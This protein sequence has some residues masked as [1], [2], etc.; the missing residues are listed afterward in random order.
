MAPAIAR[1]RARISQD[2]RHGDRRDTAHDRAQRERDEAHLRAQSRDTR[3]DRG[4]GS[5][6]GERCRGL[7]RE[8]EELRAR[9]DREWNPAER[10][11]TEFRLREVREQEERCR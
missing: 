11:R 3:Y 5:D 4:Y 8:A 10:Q 1:D 2:Y 9:L 6:R 7:R